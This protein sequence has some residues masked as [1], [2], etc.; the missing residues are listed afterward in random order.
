MGLLISQ[1]LFHPPHIATPLALSKYFWLTTSSGSKISACYIQQPSAKYTILYSH[2]NAEDLGMIYNYMTE[3]SRLLHVN[4]L[5][6][7]YSGYGV[8]VKRKE[9]KDNEIEPSEENCYADIEAA[10]D[11]LTNVRYVNPQRIV[12]Y[13]R[14]VGSGPSCYLAQKISGE[15]GSSGLAG[16]ILHSP[17][18]SVCRVVVDVG[19]ENAFD[20]FP[21]VSRIRKVTCPV[22]I[23]HGTKDAIVPFY[24]GR[25]MYEALPD[26]SRYSPPFWA[27]NM[28]HNNI[29]ADM[30]SLFVK[31]LRNFLLFLV[32]SQ[33]PD[34]INE[35]AITNSPRPLVQISLKE[36]KK[37]EST[38]L[39]PK[40]KLIRNKYPQSVQ[41][42]TDD[43]LPS[44]ST[45]I[46][47]VEARVSSFEIQEVECVVVEHRS[48]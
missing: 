48:Q 29:E 6:Y 37:D 44:N 11:F 27:E 45:N 19:V 18:L 24:H 31:K 23:I 34:V 3:L 28:G 39:F 30:A 15:K 43:R 46:V 2:G 5:A 9:N 22:F 33:T 8:G 47:K 13:G 12:L 1:V 10:F 32:S 35:E 14:S 38:I 40:S 21:N 26:N 17:F 4:I 36:S 16:M 7:D 20:V 25:C 42:M 41:E